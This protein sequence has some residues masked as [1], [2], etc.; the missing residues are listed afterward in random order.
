MNRHV[1]IFIVFLLT[2][3]SHLFGETTL[4]LTK[5]QTCDLELIMNEGFKPLTGF[6]TQQ[7]YD[8][9]VHNMR[10]ADGTLW[11]MPIVLD[12]QEKIAQ[13]LITGSQLLLKSEEG[14]RLAILH[15]RDIWKPNKVEEAQCVYGTT[16]T[17]HP[18][19]H[20]LLHD[21]K[22]YYVG[23]TIEK[24]ALPKY[25][26]F[27]ELRKTPQELKE[28]FKEKGITKVVAFQTRNPM[29][30][31]HVELTTRAMQEIGGHLL[32]HP[33]VGLTKP[34]DV[35][36]FTRVKCYKKLLNY[37]PQDS[38]TLS[39][40]PISMRMA[41][42]R[43]AVWHALIRKNYGATH[44]IVGRDHAGP[45]K[46]R[47]GRD[48]YGP[49]DAQNLVKQYEKEIGVTVIPFNQMVYIEQLKTYVPDNEIPQGTNVLNISGTQFRK[50][51]NDGTEIPS[52]FSYTEIVE[53]LRK[54]YRKKS[55]QG[56]TIFF[57]GLSGAG[58]STLANA[59]AIKLTELQHRPI[60]ILDGDIIRQHLSSELGFSKEHRS[61][62]VRRVGFVASEITKNGGIALCALVSPYEK[63]RM[64][65][66]HLISEH[67]GYIE[68]YVSTPLA[69]CE[70]RDEK[71]LYAKAKQGLIANFTGI[72][73]PYEA[74][75]HPELAIDTTQLD[76]AQAVELIIN[77]L[78]DEGY[79][80]N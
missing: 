44:F 25:H 70:E 67:G 5:R 73:D 12:V 57:T 6:L 37:Y 42:P 9:V 68:I 1:M 77:K 76:I 22:D 72:N 11:P 51:L 66:R 49:Y 28:Y 69:T 32:L 45:G 7:D 55:E 64:A 47:N 16:N 39:L 35:D 14:H 33:A 36:H 48:F 46:D 18:G 21:T 13:Q 34:G 54:V 40:L 4:T 24:I 20:Y 2:V 8:N 78:R 19:V 17:D 41:G 59:L 75:K 56:C 58:K 60:T 61:I 80:T 53:E 50:M 74:P 10:L 29:H 15:V 3:G 26:D 27:V 65:N 63:D 52:W 43:E 30:R 71:G 31:A 23:G 79:L 38:V 62:N